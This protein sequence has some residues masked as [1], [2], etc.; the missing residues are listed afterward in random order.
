M[1]KLIAIF[2]T[3]ATL[4]SVVSSGAFALSQNVLIMGDANLDAKVNIKDATYI[5]KFVAKILNFTEESMICSDCNEDEKINIKDATAIQ[6]YL[7]KMDSAK[8]L[9]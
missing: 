7:A 1:K 8:K 2:L 4:L 3:L 9:V 5:Q 6:K